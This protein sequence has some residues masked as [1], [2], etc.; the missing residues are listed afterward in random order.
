MRDSATGGD[1][2][3]M[4]DATT[5]ATLRSGGGPPPHLRPDST[6]ALA[7]LL[8]HASPTS[9]FRIVGA[10]SWPGI[11]E[12]ITANCVLDLSALQGITEYV[13]GD[14]TLTAHAGTPLS[15]IAATTAAHGQWLPLDPWGAG[16]GTLGATLATAS[17]GPLAAS[18]GLPRDA[19]LGIT[20]ADASGTLITAGGRVVKNV[21]GFDL[22]RLHV[23]AWGTLGILCEATVRLRPMPATDRSFALSLPRGARDLAE[24]TSTIQRCSLA[25]LATELVNAPLAAAMGLPPVD[26]ACVRWGGASSAVAAGHD[27]LARTAHLVE[28]PTSAWAE[29]RSAEP[30]DA[31]VVRYSTRPSELPRL[32]HAIASA[33]TSTA[34]FHAT[35]A[36]GVVRVMAPVEIQEQVMTATASLQP[37]IVVERGLQRRRPPT[38]VDRLNLT[39]REA[40]D[41]ARRLNPGLMDHARA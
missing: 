3:M 18:I 40:Y 6:E 5:S 25:P 33:D 32:W 11:A 35:V 36:R 10:G 12:R 31:T 9:T 23:G 2:A 21:A 15:V 39:I 24:L 1:T 38:A 20:V 30:H 37:H 22:V 16:D 7:E 8:R 26:T 19:A 34:R 17:A 13:P 14:L 28:I 29:L 41:P 4:S 27:A